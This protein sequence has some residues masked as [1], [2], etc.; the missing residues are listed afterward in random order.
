[1]SSETSASMIS[2]ATALTDSLITS[3]CSSRSTFRTTSSIVILL[4]CP[5]IA[6]LLVR[7]TVKKSDDDERRG[8]R[9]YNPG[10]SE[11]V[12]H[13]ATGRD[14]SAVDRHGGWSVG[15]DRSWP[16]LRTAR[17]AVKPWSVRT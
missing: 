17:G 5:A 14:L 7:R 12:L 6:G 13:H 1:M 16:R 8:G 10:P 9:T 2:C 11:P 4:C 3:A 15:S